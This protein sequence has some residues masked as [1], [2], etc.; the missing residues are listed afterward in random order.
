[1]GKLSIWRQLCKPQFV[2]QDPKIPTL[3]GLPSAKAGAIA[4]GAALMSAFLVIPAVFLAASKDPSL[5]NAGVWLSYLIWAVFV[6][7]TLVFIRLEKGWGSKWLKKH[8]LQ[9]TVIVVASPFVAIVLEHAIMPLVSVLFSM[10]NFISLSYIVKIFS[11]FK[12]IK[13]LHL[14]EVRQKV[15]KAAYRVTWLYRIAMASIA[16]C[17]LGILGAAASG[18]APTPVHGLELWW[19]LLN[20]S[21]AVAPELFVVSLPIVFF[22]GGF[23][24]FQSRLTSRQRR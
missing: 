11:G 13:L 20:Q 5:K 3:F 7:E 14:E 2:E 18:D 19:E 24:F 1:M 16:L 8:W 17:G 9:M 6:A 22:I 23:A 4:A 21:I 12:I 15:R 10:Q